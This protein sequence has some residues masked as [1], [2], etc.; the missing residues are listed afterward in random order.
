MDKV[1]F[2]RIGL[3]GTSILAIWH[4][5]VAC[6][7]EGIAVGL[8]DITER[9]QRRT[10]IVSRLQVTLYGN[11][12]QARGRIGIGYRVMEQPTDSERIAHFHLGWQSGSA[13]GRRLTLDRSGETVIG[14]S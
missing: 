4:G 2:C 5:D 1:S 9:G 6:L 12:L 7:D 11:G 3:S 14:G 8:N 10:I 13:L